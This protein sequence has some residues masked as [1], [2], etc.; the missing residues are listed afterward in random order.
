[1]NATKYADHHKFKVWLLKAL[2]EGRNKSSYDSFIDEK[3]GKVCTFNKLE[4]AAFYKTREP[5]VAYVDK[6]HYAPL[7]ASEKAQQ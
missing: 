7:G 3:F 6:S 5:L 4:D 2:K 1:M